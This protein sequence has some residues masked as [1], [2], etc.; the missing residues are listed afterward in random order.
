MVPIWRQLNITFI[1][2][3]IMLMS[4]NPPCDFNLNQSQGWFWLD[5]FYQDKTHKQMVRCRDNMSK[6]NQKT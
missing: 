3:V 4:L 5:L 6:A 1:V 2:L